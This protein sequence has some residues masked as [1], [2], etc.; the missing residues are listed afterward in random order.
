MVFPLGCDKPG[1]HETTADVP[2]S[3]EGMVWIPAGEFTMGSDAVDA[4]AEER[5]THRVRVDGFFIDTREV[6]NAQFAAFVQA[7]EYVT[8]A[9]RPIDW[10]VMKRQLPPG[11][12][13]P[14][15]DRL[16][17]GSVVFQQPSA[18]R[19][20]QWAWVVGA[21]WRFP[22]GPSSTI[23]ARMDHPVVH[24]AFE[25]ALAFAEWAGKR[26]PTEAEWERAARGGLERAVYVWGNEPVSD[27]APMANIWQGVFPDRNDAVDGFTATAPVGS[28]DQNAWGL[29][30][31]A[32]NVWEW[33]SDFYRAD[34]YARRTAENPGET[35]ENPAGPAESWW[36]G[37]EFETLRSIRGGSFLCHVTYCTRYRVSARTGEAED[38]GTSNIGFRC[39]KDA[40]E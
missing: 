36:P 40:T 1:D 10:D 24:V 32:G 21:N 22:E 38:T 5:P 17:P 9:E 35:I 15:D 26:L 33:C 34:A 16:Q 39:V 4:L 8:V 6:S 23:E 12:P 37:R 30:D 19:P 14:S 7:T 11:T 27:A 3:P 29:F 18:G 20:G 2:K 28:F 25:D 31:M 13:K